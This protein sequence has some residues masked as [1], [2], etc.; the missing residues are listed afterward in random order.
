MADIVAGTTVVL[1]ATLTDAATGDALDLSGATVTLRLAP[2]SGASVL[3]SGSA[4]DI[5]DPTTGSVTATIANSVILA[6]GDW[7]YE[8]LVTFPDGTTTAQL[9]FGA[10]SVRAQLR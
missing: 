7:N 1:Q 10:L 6:P 4:I 9:A 3:L 5:T 2:P 8:F